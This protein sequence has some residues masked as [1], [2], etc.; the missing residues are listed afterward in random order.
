MPQERSSPISTD[1]LFERMKK[2]VNGFRKEVP[3]LFFDEDKECYDYDKT[4][5]KDYG[6]ISR[7]EMPD[8][9]KTM[10]HKMT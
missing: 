6:F 5:R 8:S 10:N 4:L 7:D 2:Q 3:R 1:E 9:R